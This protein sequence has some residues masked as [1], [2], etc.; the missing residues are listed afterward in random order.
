MVVGREKKPAAR[1]GFWL[2]EEVRGKGAEELGV[3]SNPV[4]NP[5]LGD[6]QWPSL[7]GWVLGS[8]FGVPPPSFLPCS[9]VLGD[10]LPCRVPVLGGSHLPSL[11]P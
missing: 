10:S 8:L 4:Q 9:P 11:L 5:D 1:S 2:K 7:A 6:P 3:C